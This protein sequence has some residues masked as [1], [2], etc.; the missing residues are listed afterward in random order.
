MRE[1]N[2]RRKECVMCKGNEDKQV[3]TQRVG[4]KHSEPDIRNLP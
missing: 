3:E 1:K 2:F 4:G